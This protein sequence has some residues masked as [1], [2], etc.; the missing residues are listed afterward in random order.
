MA[1]DEYVK[2]PVNFFHGGKIKRIRTLPN[3]ETILLVWLNLLYIAGAINDGGAVYF[4]PKIPYTAE[5]LSEEIGVEA[6]TIRQALEIL[7][8]YEMLNISDKAIYIS[9]WEKWKSENSAAD[10]IEKIK[11]QNR[12]RAKAYRERKK[13][14]STGGEVFPSPALQGVKGLPAP[15]RNTTPTSTKKL[16]A[17]FE[18]FWN[19]WPKKVSKGQAEKTWGKL[20]PDAELTEKI[21]AGVERAK[22]TDRRFRETEYTPHASTWLNNRGWEDVTEKGGNVIA[23]CPENDGTYGRI[24]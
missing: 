19:V 21:I 5:T 16:L 6:D 20:N 4:T 8:D 22:K 11:E 17:S 13:I 10:Q 9:Q 18:R 14:E 7:H 15:K 12:R 1:A 3:G 23:F 24:L 2:I